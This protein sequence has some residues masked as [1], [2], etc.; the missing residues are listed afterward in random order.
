LND[1]F[2]DYVH[3]RRNYF[4]GDPV[5]ISRVRR[6]EPELAQW[7][8]RLTSELDVVL[9][10]LKRHFPFHSPRYIGHMLSEQ[11]LP[12]VLGYF[13]GMLYNPNNVTDEAAPITVR[14]EIEVGQMVAEMLG[15]DPDQTWAHITSGGTIAN[16]EALWVARFTQC[17]PFMVREY[18]QAEREAGRDA[19]FLITTADGNRIPLVDAEDRV[20]IGLPPDESVHMVKRIIDH[21]CDSMGRDPKAVS[22]MIKN[23]MD[24]SVYNI[25]RAGFR[26]FLDKINLE[27]LL[28]VSAAAHYSIKKAADV[29]GYGEAAVRVVPV[30]PQFRIDVEQLRRMLEDV[31]DHQY[32][33]AVIGI[34]GTTE[35]GAVDPIHELQALRAERSQKRNAAFWLHADAA[36]GGYIA[37]LFRGYPSIPV[38][39]TQSGHITAQQLDDHYRMYMD[40]INASEEVSI[41][42]D[43]NDAETVYWKDPEV[44]KAYL[45]LLEADSITVDPQKLGYIPYPAGVV[46]F[47]NGEITELIEQKAPYISEAQEYVGAVKGSERKAIGPY[48]LEGSKPGAAATACWLAHKTIPLDAT[49][50]G[51]IMRATLLN[52]KKLAFHLRN[53]KRRFEEIHNDAFNGGRSDRHF[54]FVPLCEPDT[55]IVCF[56]ALPMIRDRSGSWHEEPIE[57]TWINKLNEGILERLSISIEKDP[58]WLPYGQPYFVSRTTF[59]NPPYESSSLSSVLKSLGIPIE[60]YE[61]TKNGLFVLRSTVMNPFYHEAE[62]QGMDYIKDFI[63][64]LH[65]ETYEVLGEVYKERSEFMKSIGK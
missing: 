7:E 48:I 42:I 61:T 53:H 47:R 3:W 31:T 33:A 10:E 21:L 25:R 51:R 8:D 20:L 40:A 22:L 15:Y 55:N 32:V 59:E 29:L 14:W 57:L 52:A 28:F 9:N 16:L 63:G 2:Q 50:H 41:A 44:Y 60:E 12:S 45:S 30:T 11:T 6:R 62:G 18:C 38:E 19:S 27:P 1:V 35:E 36:W 26:S 65:H 56:V 64:F 24:R 39:R 34:V 49:G 58:K 43:G 37:A 4:P 54:V 46:A 13:A 5:T 17:I 23:T